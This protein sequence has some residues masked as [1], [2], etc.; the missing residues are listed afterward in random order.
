MVAPQRVRVATRVGG[1]RRRVRDPHGKHAR[2]LAIA[3]ALALSTEQV[4]RRVAGS[5]DPR[6]I[7]TAVSRSEPLSNLMRLMRS[8]GRSGSSARHALLGRRDAG[9][10]YPAIDPIDTLG[11]EDKVRVLREAPAVVLL[12]SGS[13][14][15]RM[16]ASCAASGLSWWSASCSSSRSTARAAA[17]KTRNIQ[18]GETINSLKGGKFLSVR[19]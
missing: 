4:V 16:T 2:N 18:G 6:S 12:G 3:I 9:A 17:T 1:P 10:L 15:A 11:S 13:S 5:G 8:V 14:A 19:H 7:A